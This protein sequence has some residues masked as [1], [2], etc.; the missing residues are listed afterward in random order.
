MI[1]TCPHEF[2]TADVWDLLR[3]ADLA[4]KGS[5]PVAGGWLDQTASCVDG[6]RFAWA[7]N[8]LYD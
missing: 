8:A 7:K 2:V 1:E 3:A 6:V 4:E 5:W